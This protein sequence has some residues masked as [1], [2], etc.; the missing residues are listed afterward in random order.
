MR[1]LV[2][3]VLIAM[4]IEVSIAGIAYC[5]YQQDIAF[6]LSFSGLLVF[7][8]IELVKTLDSAD[9]RQS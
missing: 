6:S 3:I 8:I 9:R 4:A 7:S 2:L 5:A 1:K